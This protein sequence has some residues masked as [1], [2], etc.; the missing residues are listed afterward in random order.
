MIKWLGPTNEAEMRACLD[1]TNI[2]K[3][4]SLDDVLKIVVDA[5][6]DDGTSYNEVIGALG[7][8]K[9]SSN[10]EAMGIGEESCQ[11]QERDQ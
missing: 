1:E 4:A 11:E 10:C 9:F 2:H 8:I 5:Y 3:D 6:L 7:R